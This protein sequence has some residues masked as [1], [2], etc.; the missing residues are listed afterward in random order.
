[1]FERLKSAAKSVSE[2]I[3]TTV[4]SIDSTKIRANRAE[5]G[6]TGR[7]K[8]VGETLSV[9]GAKSAW[10]KLKDVFNKDAA[11]KIPKEKLLEI[12][13]SQE[14]EISDPKLLASRNELAVVNESLTNPNNSRAENDALYKKQ[15]DLMRELHSIKLQKI[16]PDGT[17]IQDATISQGQEN[18]KSKIEPISN[19][20]VS[21][22][23]YDSIYHDLAKKVS[24]E[25]KF[26]TINN[27]S[28]IEN[29]TFGIRSKLKELFSKNKKIETHG[30]KTIA[31]HKD[32]NL[33]KSLAD[34]EDALRR[35]KIDELESNYRNN[36][37]QNPEEIVVQ[38]TP[39]VE[40]F[41][42]EPE[43]RGGTQTLH[44]KEHAGSTSNN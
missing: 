30:A 23:V 2:K 16:N 15:A 13:D 28:K 29:V 1:M 4:N 8:E 39:E 20:L 31:E 12:P 40:P 25:T 18:P 3:K 5:A 14:L 10:G 41:A 24:G 26:M 33:A 44:R 35:R 22:H 21:E 6:I 11:N 42:N 36:E 7:D 27:N 38:S 37:S 17:I 43:S 32:I 9:D 34:R 19:G